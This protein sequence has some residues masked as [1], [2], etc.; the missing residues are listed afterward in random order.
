MINLMIFIR[1]NIIEIKFSDLITLFVLGLI[2]SLMYNI[3]N[4]I[5][6]SDNYLE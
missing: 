2:H 5:K 1:I 4:T 3:L 6:Y